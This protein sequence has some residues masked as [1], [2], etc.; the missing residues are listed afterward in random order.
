MPE[1]VSYSSYTFPS[2]APLV[3]KSSEMIR[4]R[5]K[6]DHFIDQVDVVGNL[7]GANLSGLHLQKMQMTSGMLTEFGILSISNDTETKQYK[8]ATPISISF[9]NSDLT[10]VLPYSVS[11]SSPSSGAFSEFFGVTDPQDVW[12]FNE[13]DGKMVNASHRVSAKGVKTGST[14]PLVTARHFVTGRATGC[15]GNLGVFN[16]GGNAFLT[17]R[18]EDINK[19]ENI[20]GLTENYA[21]STRTTGI[22]SDSGIVSTSASISYDKT[23]GLSVSVNGSI[24]GSIDANITGGLLTTG[25]FTP[26]QAQDVA[27]NAV[28][29]S[30]SDY[31]SGCYSFINRGPTI[32]NYTVNT[33]QNKIDFNFS[34][35]DPDNVDQTGNVAHKKSATV[36]ASKDESNITVAIQGELRYNAP[37]EIMGTGNPVTGARFQEVEQA[38][39]GVRDNSGFLNLAVENLKCFREDAT[40]YYISGD[41]INST[42]TSSG[43]TKN[44]IEG[45]ISYSLSFHNKLDLSSGSL[46]GL[47]VS[48]SDK[49]PIELSGIVPSVA[50]FA[51]QKIFNRTLGEYG[52]AASCEGSTGELAT[53]EQVVS[54][55][56]TGVYD[57]N[58]S[59]SSSDET[60][61]FNL[62]RF[63]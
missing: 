9:S 10:T 25:N 11:F 15:I 20:Y 37:F 19:A 48:I 62:N 3:A 22:I 40:G 2:P 42:P 57:I 60:L 29:S 38:F 12:T 46:T 5:G 7:T 26:T 4:V 51:K 18:T 1:T 27:I 14:N 30:L 17:A 13:E 45:F 61:S 28:V 59:S 44:P 54:G 50:G 63:Y 8:Q 6:L 36:T 47:R 24:F 33:G 32:Y 53:L 39:S 21:F 31:E 58:K 35:S 56:I 55:Y 49:K 41:Y 43:V 52:V 23:A 16:T 34:F